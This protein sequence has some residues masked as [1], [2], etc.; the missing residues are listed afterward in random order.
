ML[1]LR[2]ESPALEWLAVNAKQ[3]ELAQSQGKSLHIRKESVG[4]DHPNTPE[5]YTHLRVRI[6]FWVLIQNIGTNPPANSYHC[7]EGFV[8]SSKGR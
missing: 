7:L 2:L 5:K 1:A 6:I 8:L 4:H 3:E